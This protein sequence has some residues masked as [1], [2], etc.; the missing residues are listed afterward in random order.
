[1]GLIRTLLAGVATVMLIA[2]L[3]VAVSHAA[4]YGSPQKNQAVL[5]P[6]RIHVLNPGPSGKQQ[7][8]DLIGDPEAGRSTF[9][10]Y[11]VRCH[12][13]AGHG[14]G[15]TAMGLTPSP[16]D[17]T[18]TFSRWGPLDDEVVT[19]VEQYVYENITYGIEGSDE[20]QMPAWGPVLSKQ[21]R[22]NLV[23]FIKSIAVYDD[24]SDK[25]TASAGGY[26]TGVGND[27]A[28]YD[29]VT[30]EP[31]CE[32]CHTKDRRPVTQY[33]DDPECLKCHKAE[34]SERF[35]AIDERFK[36]PV[37]DATESYRH[38]ARLE[39]A[40]SDVS[41]NIPET[42]LDAPEGMVWV[43][44]GA[45]IMG[46]NDWWPKS[47]PEHTRELPDYFI[48]K[49][50][51]TNAD[52]R[53]FVEAT[54]DSMPEH[55]KEGVIPEGREQHPVIYVSWFDATAYCEWRGKSLPTEPEWEKAARGTDGRTFPWGNQFDKNKANTP[56]YG[57][58]DSTPVG[59]FEEG[60][61]PYGAHDMA[62]NVFEWTADWY[63]AFPGN[64]HPDPNEGERYRV[65]KG[66]SWYDCTY[67]KC[68]IS[69][70]T[71]N[72]IFFDPETRNDNFGFRCA[73]RKE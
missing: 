29:P 20:L 2:G 57:H 12:G 31:L 33:I 71:Y 58:K 54:G 49:Y 18:K 15:T 53:E 47:G 48:D 5:I 64:Q 46:T 66:G 21:D 55:W 60:R 61:S 56:Q 50:E 68:G 27:P 69:A 73:L 70:P 16:A 35:L 63:K 40:A 42:T 24:T 39:Q 59:Q 11:C 32:I 3:S 22:A 1:M 65:V 62:G 51:V 44:G 17:L 37:E 41:N 13:E 67:Y 36:V 14:D 72:R 8:G 45:F 7:L 10:K 34:Y 38:H 28:E 19:M 52:Y 30:G 6:I 9:K 25:A 26:G 23:A 43:P 4:G